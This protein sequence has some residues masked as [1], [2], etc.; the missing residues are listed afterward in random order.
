MQTIPSFL[1]LF[2]Q[3]WTEYQS[4]FKKLAGL[5]LW[6]IPPLLLLILGASGIVGSFGFAFIQNSKHFVWIGVLL[7]SLIL[8]AALIGFLWADFTFLNVVLKPEQPN[9]WRTSHAR[10]LPFFGFTLLHAIITILSFVLFIIPGIIVTIWFAFA[11]NYFVLGGGIIDSLKKSRKL[12]ENRW[13]K[14]ALHLFALY[15]CTTI[16]LQF[17][18]YILGRIFSPTSFVVSLVSNGL[19]LF[20]VLPM[21]LIYVK[22]LREAAEAEDASSINTHTVVTE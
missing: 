18:T 12:T 6:T 14:I 16:P 1:T 19:A 4:R 9:P 5:L 8:I 17:I 7:S 11:A 21:V 15:L 22:Q 2:E 3:T 13:W 20:V 10:L